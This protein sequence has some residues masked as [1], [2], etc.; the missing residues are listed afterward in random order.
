MQR[1]PLLKPREVAE[2]LGI[3]LHTLYKWVESG[4]L[5]AVKVGGYCLR[6]DPEKIEKLVEKWRT[7]A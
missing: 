1:R 4:K 2:W 5:P 7:A 6:F 3:S